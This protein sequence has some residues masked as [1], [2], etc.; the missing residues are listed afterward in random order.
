MSEVVDD[1]L[2]RENREDCDDDGVREDLGRTAGE[3]CGLVELEVF[4]CL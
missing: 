3:E 4:E 1:E 2:C